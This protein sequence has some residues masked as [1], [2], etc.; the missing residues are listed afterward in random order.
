[1]GTPRLPGRRGG[2]LGFLKRALGPRQKARNDGA[3]PLWRGLV[4]AFG[5]AAAEKPWVDRAQAELDEPSQRERSGDERWAS[6]RK[7]LAQARQ[8]DKDGK[9]DEANRL[10][11]TLRTLYADDPSARAILDKE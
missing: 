7:A 4:G 8:L 1:E 5:A 6:V 2:P 3:R 9:H 11:Q 10:R